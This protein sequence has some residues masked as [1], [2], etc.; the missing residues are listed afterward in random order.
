[1]FYVLLAAHIVCKVKQSPSR[2]GQ[3]LRVP[4]GW[5]SQISR[6]SAHEGGKVVSLTHRPPLPPGNIPGTHF[7]Q[8]LSHPQGHG[9]TRRIMSMKN[10][11]DTIGNRA[12]DLPAC[13]AVPQPTA[14]P[15]AYP[16]TFYVP[17]LN[18]CTCTF[19]PWNS[20]TLNLKRL[21]TVFGSEMSKLSLVFVTKTQSPGMGM[22][23]KMTGDLVSS[24]RA[25]S[26]CAVLAKDIA[27]PTL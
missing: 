7:W 16:R 9:V 3:A 11:N 1:M 15:H 4:G 23:Q 5:S 21:S 17:V 12:R 27:L 26:Y 8:R 20:S 18:L 14:P 24:T 19:W 13:S 6:Q 25:E 22:S 2:P 10:S